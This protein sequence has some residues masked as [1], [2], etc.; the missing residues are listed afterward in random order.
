MSED[1]DES[2]KTEEP[3][4][5]RLA[6]AR[7]RGQVATSR[8]LN[9]W[10]LLFAA[11]LSIAFIAPFFSAGLSDV[12][13]R[14][15]EQ[16]HALPMETPRTVGAV[17]YDTLVD[18]TFLLT[19]PLGLFFVLAI[20]T[21]VVQNGLNFAPK[22]IEPKFEKISP[23]AGL[24]RTFGGR[25]LVE[26][27]KGN[28]KIVLVGAIGVLVL[29]PEVDRLDT[30]V[31]MEPLFILREVYALVIEM[32]IGML[33]V[34]SV[35]TAF[36]VLYQ[37]Y[38]HRKQLMMT[39]QEVKEEFKQAEGDPQ[40]KA[41]LRQIRAERARRRMMQAVPEADVVITNPT[42]YAVALAYD[43]DRMEAP[44]LVAKGQD[45]LALKIRE[46]A[47]ENEVPL[48][49]NPPLARAL[50]AAV[51]IDETIPEEHYKAVAEVISYVWS[52][53]GHLPRKPASG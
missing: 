45:N 16:P 5:K 7:D 43:P 41:K 28:V 32:M 50:H 51:E 36:D 14:F 25:N 20:A 24:K 49:E 11:T 44:T 26:F 19:I 9:S 42:H 17:L 40:I 21:G 37:R 52:L 6:E 10:V 38:A 22:A 15:V 12:M 39:R 34:F 46:I 30:L 48:V 47:R 31:S 4:G 18:A 1:A 2:Q 13:L 35:I 53:K 33:A 29:L 27:A 3:T 23:L 8:E